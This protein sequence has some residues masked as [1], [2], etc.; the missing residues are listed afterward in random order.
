MTLIN[1]PSPQQ[2]K[3]SITTSVPPL[4]S[5][6]ERGHLPTQ[7][8]VYLPNAARAGVYLDAL[9]AA[10]KEAAKQGCAWCLELS[11]I[12]KECPCNDEV[13]V[14]VGFE[15]DFEPYQWTPLQRELYIRVRSENRPKSYNTY[16]LY[17][18]ATDPAAVYIAARERITNLSTPESFRLAQECI[19]KCLGSHAN[20]QKPDL[21]TLLPD[22]VLDCS[23]PNNPKLVL[24]NGTQ[25]GP[26]LTLSY[27]WGDDEQL[28]TTTSN[29]DQ[30]V[31][32]G[33]PSTMLPPTIRDA[34]FVTHSLKQQFLWVDALCILQDSEEDKV[35]QLSGM[36]RI[37]RE[38]YLTINAAM[39]AS[40]KEGFLRQPRKQRIPI[41]RLPFC[42][43]NDPTGVTTGVV[44]MA[45]AYAYRGPADP[46]EYRGWTL[47]E[48]LLP[49][50]SL[51][52]DSE[53][54]KYYCH[55]EIVSIG[56][57]LCEPSMLLRLPQAAGS[58]V[59]TQRSG[60]LSAEKKM[61]VRH[62][63]Q[64]VIT[65]YTPRQLSDER[66]K[67]PALAGVVEQFAH[68]TGD[69]YLAG[70]WKENL[71]FDLLWEVFGPK[72][73]DQRP[74][75]YRAPSWSWA[76]VDG[77]VWPK[78]WY[79]QNAAMMGENLRKAEVI[80]CWVKLAADEAPFG[81][82]I[83]ALLSIKAVMK[84]GVV[85]DDWTVVVSWIDN[86]GNLKE[87]MMWASFDDRKSIP[88]AVAIVPIIW[89][90]GKRFFRGLVLEKLSTGRF[91]RVGV[92]WSCSHEWMHGFA[93]EVIEII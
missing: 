70:L 32:H 69:V 49:P 14:S 18:A 58:P 2:G 39:A 11:R 47:Q 29:I 36:G 73:N 31:S 33:I 27:V 8:S 9:G 77:A 17:T 20:C 46:I 45:K 38:S 22:R 21:S 59:P 72:P 1:L 80:D 61:E 13:A 48:K 50:R 89:N 88:G 37:Y 76:S 54:L 55:T 25:R 57:A 24:T 26:Y 74:R 4:R 51:I 71:L 52:Y 44:C 23:D 63:W 35:R 30:H 64:S 86:L 56:Q 79:E 28:T 16:R 42:D 91:K 6:R 83:D 43:P 5:T 85:L 15:Q 75:R 41:A 81:E 19:G 87:E 67:L 7:I 53:T 3:D 10:V 82:V 93:T 40:T 34:V 68:V 78:R 84:K 12:L 60:K 66:D 65:S 62:A 90:A 92:F